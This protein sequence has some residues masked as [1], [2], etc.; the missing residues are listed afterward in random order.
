MMA[1]SHRF[2]DL[3][4]SYFSFTQGFVTST[5]PPPTDAPA[6]QDDDVDE[7]ESS[8]S[9]AGLIAGAVIG[10]L[11]GCALL[12]GLAYLPYQTYRAKLRRAKELQQYLEKSQ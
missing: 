2:Y 7:T 6:N 5:A 10:A 4:D 12:S 9:D 8:G 11:G 1:E 3:A